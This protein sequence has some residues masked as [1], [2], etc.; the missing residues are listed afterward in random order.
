PGSGRGK[1]PSGKVRPE[2]AVQ[3]YVRPTRPSRRTPSAGQR[4]GL[5]FVKRTRTGIGEG[6]GNIATGGVTSRRRP[7]RH[8][9]PSG[10]VGVPSSVAAGR[11]RA[12]G[13]GAGRPG[14]AGAR[15]R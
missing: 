2:G 11:A 6:T 9:G 1:R 12:R 8:A 14:R 3:P 13:G 15:G 7:A 5:A 10:A 4:Q